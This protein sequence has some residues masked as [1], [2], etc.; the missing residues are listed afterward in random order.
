MESSN[1]IKF[2]KA[3]PVLNFLKAHF[4]GLAL[5][6]LE[7][8]SKPNRV[9]RLI[10]SHDKEI[11][12]KCYPHGQGL[13]LKSEG[14]NIIYPVGSFKN[15][16]VFNFIEPKLSTSWEK[17]KLLY[18]QVFFLKAKPRDLNENLKHR[19]AVSK[20]QKSLKGMDDKKEDV[21]NQ[22][23]EKIL[24]LESEL[25]TA[26]GRR[27]NDIHHEIKKLKRRII[28]YGQ[29][30]NQLEK[31]LHFIKE[32][33]ENFN[34]A[35]DKVKL[36][37]GGT[38]IYLNEHFQLWVGRNANQNDDL[39]RLA[40]AHEIWLHLRD[41]A[42]AHGLIRGPKNMDPPQEIID[43][44]CLIVAQLT[45]GSKKLF[46]EGEKI[47]FVWTH[48]KFLKKTKSMAP[49]SVIVEREKVRRVAFKKVEFQVLD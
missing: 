23:T 24:I 29:K 27:I 46:Q 9:V 21:I 47:D 12:F 45:Q 2:K 20:I 19:Q 39:I 49:G 3:T 17:N 31:K 36:H 10:F 5:N 37:F 16:D 11:I 41:R 18:R 28:E 30:R 6:T 32:H 44:S 34:E 4:K 7:I 13:L 1:P 15:D 8:A 26:E 40:S 35:Q 33:P 14:K 22:T 38:R 43:Y 48:K 25:K 42:S